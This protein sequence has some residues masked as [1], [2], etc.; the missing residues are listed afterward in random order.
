[1]DADNRFARVRAAIEQIGPADHVC[2]LYDQRE[3][4]VA[5]AVSYL[6]AGLERGEF[7]VCVVDD[8]GE[9]ILNALAAAGVD[10]EA[11]MRT[12][13]LVF[14]EK[15]LAHG[16][17]TVDMLGRIEQFA[18]DSRKA[19]HAGFRIVGEMSWALNGDLKD[20]AE[21]EARL[22]LNRVWERHACAGLC[23][24][25]IRRFKPETLREMIVVHPLVVIGD[26]IC[27]NP[28]YVAPEQYLSPDWPRHEANW[29]MTNLEQLQQSQDSL[30]ES[31]QRYRSLSRQLMEQQ[32]IERGALARELHDQLGQSLVA[33]SLNLEAIEDELS[34]PS[35]ARV[36][37]STRIIKQMIE[38]VRTLAF[39]LR[40]ALLD[41][42]GLVEA[43]RDLVMRHGQRAGMRTSFTA[44]PTDARAPVEI[45]TAC[46]RIVQE[47]LSNVARHAQ[48]RHIEVRLTVQD[49][50][51][52]VTV[53]DD[54]VGLN[55]ERRRTGL[56]IMGMSERADLAGGKVDIESAPGAG[57]TVRARFP[58]PAPKR[59][60]ANHK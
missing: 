8:G 30:Q 31:Q 53:T 51:L 23:Q 38:Q 45:E 54:G 47:A 28:Y 50:A 17:Q 29:M 10:S 20:L 49:V 43:L 34:P 39:D 33:I 42:F 46:F 12:G 58:L 19:G 3:E 44:T 13:R 4:E 41:E 35:R 32:E 1:M 57:T 15:P 40:P 55:V 5:I 18:S 16:L 25:D 24:F 59:V 56:G 11:E 60:A 37:E 26:R 2:T 21:F 14:F 48:A 27:R 36:P 52:E 6:R 9:S 22:N 7:C